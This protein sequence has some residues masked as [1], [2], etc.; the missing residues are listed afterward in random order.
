MK[1]VPLTMHA[2][3]ETGKNENGRLRRAEMIPAILY[4]LGEQNRMLAISDHDFHKATDAIGNEMVMYA[5]TDKESQLD[6]QLAVIR[7]VQRDPVTGRILHIDFMR[8]DRKKSLDVE[9][10]VHPQGTPEGTR[11][12]GV[13]EYGIRAVQIRCLPDD[14]PSH[15]DADISGLNVGDSFYVSDLP[16]LENVEFLT[17]ETEMLFHVAVPRMVDEELEEEGEEGDEAAEPEVIGKKKEED[18]EE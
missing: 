13:L 9:V 10:T 6:K 14:V 7:A 16:T 3:Q 4:G 15:L 1:T 8:V 17:S 2:R 5:I 18:E 11:D 12:G